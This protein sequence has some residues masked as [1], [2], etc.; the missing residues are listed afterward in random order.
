MVNVNNES[1]IAA[2]C[3]TDS[4]V[5]LVENGFYSVRV[6]LDFNPAFST[7]RELCGSGLISQRTAAE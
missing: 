6:N 1:C 5:C 2:A 7:I 4:P 3:A